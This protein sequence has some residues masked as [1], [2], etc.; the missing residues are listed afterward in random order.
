MMVFSW[1]SE[2]MILYQAI[3]MILVGICMFVVIGCYVFFKLGQ[4]V[5]PRNGIIFSLVIFFLF[6]LLTYPWPF[7]GTNIPYKHPRGVDPVAK[8]WVSYS[9]K[10]RSLSFIPLDAKLL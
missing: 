8:E 10:V 6:Y 2:N 1:T 9:F 7:S 3:G 5:A 4:R